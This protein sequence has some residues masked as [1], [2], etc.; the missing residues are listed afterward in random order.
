MNE[1]VDHATHA[2]IAVGPDDNRIVDFPF[3]NLPVW[4]CKRDSSDGNLDQT[5]MLLE[6]QQISIWK[7]KPVYNIELRTELHS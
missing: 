5:K 7:N 3:K 6:K 1:S 4:I 2:V